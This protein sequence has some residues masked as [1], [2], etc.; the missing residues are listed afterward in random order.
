MKCWLWGAYIPPHTSAKQHASFAKQHKRGFWKHLQHIVDRHAGGSSRE[1][2]VAGDLNAHCEDFLGSFVAQG[3]GP[4]LLCE[5]SEDL[6]DW[7]ADY[8]SWERVFDCSGLQSRS[9]HF[10][11][12]RDF[13]TRSG[14]VI[15]NG[16]VNEDRGRVGDPSPTY[17]RLNSSDA[18]GRPYRA[19]LDYV[20]TS[21]RLLCGDATQGL[22]VVDRTDKEPGIDHSCVASFWRRFDTSSLNTEK[23]D[24]VTIPLELQGSWSL[25][26]RY[27]FNM[28]RWQE[29]DGRLRV[30]GDAVLSEIALLAE[31]AIAAGRAVSNTQIEMF[32][33]SFTI[34]L[35]RV[36]QE[37][38]GEPPKIMVTAD[39]DPVKTFP[40]SKGPKAG[41]RR[42]SNPVSETPRALQNFLDSD[43]LYSELKETLYGF[44][45]SLLGNRVSPEQAN[46]LR[47]KWRVVQREL[48][49]RRKELENIFWDLQS[50]QWD[51][52]IKYDAGKIYKQVRDITKPSVRVANSISGDSWTR[53]WL[54]VFVPQT[55]PDEAWSD[56]QLTQTKEL[57][58]GWLG[59]AD[60]LSPLLG[61]PVTRAEVHRAIRAT[62][63]A[64]AP[65]AD[66]LSA[67]VLHACDDVLADRLRAIFDLVFRSGHWPA[68]WSRSIISL[69]KKP[70]AVGDKCDEYRGVTLLSCLGKTA[71]AIILKRLSQQVRIGS[72]Q[73]GF[74]A[75]GEC[76]DNLL[77]FRHIYEQEVLF[78]VDS[79]S[80]DAARGSL[81]RRPDGS[82]WLEDV[83]QGGTIPE[84]VGEWRS[85]VREQR[86]NKPGRVFIFSSDI[87]KAFP[88]VSRPHLLSQLRSA[89][90]EVKLAR[91]IHSML[92]STEAC[93]INGRNL[94]S[95]F[96]VTGGLRE[97]CLCSPVLWT[98][99]FDS[100]LERL[101]S[102]PP[103]DEDVYISGRPMR[104]MAYA[105]DLVLVAR[106]QAR[107][108]TLVDHYR[109][110]C[111]EQRVT[112]SQLKSACM[113]LHAPWDT[114]V[115]YPDGTRLSDDRGKPIAAWNTVL[116][117]GSPLSIRYG[118]AN[119]R[120]LRKMRY[121]GIYI[122]D[123]RPTQ[124]AG[125]SVI[126]SVRGCCAML[127]GV[128][129]TVGIRRVSNIWSFFRSMV[130]SRLTFSGAAWQDS[131]VE[132]ELDEIVYHF[133]RWICGAKRLAYRDGIMAVASPTG[134]HH[135]MICLRPDYVICPS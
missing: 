91:L 33:D 62:N 65:G 49:L 76:C 82:V 104:S 68:A 58:E 41:K 42:G 28:D 115:S 88:W 27:R 26:E 127:K 7:V 111:A 128:V 40:K 130:V 51:T 22:L 107:L 11:K 2:V 19:T 114:G 54:Q 117:D 112:V 31:E 59:S 121:L 100:L 122:E 43:P 101:D 75:G 47:P 17:F 12:L 134:G 6:A 52:E 103:S 5:R 32:T 132:E 23:P 4:Q 110:W 1:V 124:A 48:R 10:P 69:V 89:N 108:Q 53:H 38:T 8:A 125:Q 116:V 109:A 126:R 13:C 97:G 93:V 66:G 71:S 25:P 57:V 9:Q 46:I 77:V 73:R 86:K 39:R 15:L 118:N 94:G 18:R 95:S 102:L 84:S 36:I 135:L 61:G 78:S 105:D 16:L 50:R 96:K 35:Q 90:V 60:R 99:L 67:R 72:S 70:G 34:S 45:R 55:N 113:V 24:A 79:A 85:A 56:E 44:N 120:W 83:F 29:S 92:S 98:I 21:P 106:S 20:I 63:V 123:V 74:V 37:S 119:I 14:L 30:Q 81:P 129:R 3:E 87:K 80:D 64:S 131:H 133:A